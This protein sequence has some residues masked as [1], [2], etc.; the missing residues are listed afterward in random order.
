MHCQGYE[1]M[2]GPAACAR[3]PKP[4]TLLLRT[5]ASLSLTP[6]TSTGSSRVDNFP[7]TALP[8]DTPARECSVSLSVPT[9]KERSATVQEDF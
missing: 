2:I 3:A 6:L 9:E 7:A 8:P 4:N 5:S 1:E